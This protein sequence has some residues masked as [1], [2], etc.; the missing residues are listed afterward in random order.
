MRRPWSIGGCRAKNKTHVSK[1]LSSGVFLPS[2]PIQKLHLFLSS[3]MRAKCPA[4]FLLLDFIT[5]ITSGYDSKSYS[6][7]CAIFSGHL[8]LFLRSSHNSMCPAFKHHQSSSAV[9]QFSKIY[10][11]SQN[12]KPQKCDMK[13]FPY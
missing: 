1:G 3:P 9:Q 2:F 6:F 10:G 8:L 13:Q 4:H 7:N 5:L 11:P 12:S